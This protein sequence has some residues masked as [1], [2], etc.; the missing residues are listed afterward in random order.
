MNTRDTHIIKAALDFLHEREA[1]ITDIIIHNET[2][3]RVSPAP[4]NAEYAAAMQH[5]DQA[6]WIVSVPARF[7]TGFKRSITEQGEAVRLEMNL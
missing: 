7:G 3:L 6:G 4:S 2:R 5:A 1:Q